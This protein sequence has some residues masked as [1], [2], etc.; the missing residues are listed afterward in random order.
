MQ[1]TEFSAKNI[2]GLPKNEL[3][4]PEVR[5][6]IG[7]VVEITGAN[8][9]GKTS[10]AEALRAALSGGSL[11]KLRSVDAKGDAEATVVFDDGRFRLERVGD[12]LVLRE[13]VKNDRKGD[14]YKKVDAP[15]SQLNLW[16][17]RD[18]SNPIRFLR[19]VQKERLDLFLKALPLT[20]TEDQVREALGAD[21]LSYE[22]VR[23][24]VAEGGHPL[25]LL[26]GLHGAIYAERR[27]INV[28]ERQKRDAVQELTQDVSEQDEA[29]TQEGVS[30]LES[31]RDDRA[32]RLA[33]A[34]ADADAA[35]LNAFNAAATTRKTYES[36]RRV[37]LAEEIE[38]LQRAAAEDIKAALDRE[39]EARK[40]A[41]TVF[42]AAVTALASDQAAVNAVTQRLAEARA[43]LEQAAKN[44]RTREL[45]LKYEAEADG[46][47]GKSERLTAGLDAIV[48]LKAQLLSA[49]PIPGLEV[50]DKD[51][52]VNG[53]PFDQLNESAQLELATDVIILRANR[54]P[55]KVAFIDGA[56]VFSSENRERIK[57]KLAAAD[58]QAVICR[59]TDGPLEV[60]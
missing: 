7:S 12:E 11:N 10:I 5:L 9:L 47:K 29:G 20:L 55:L 60:A 37:R 27:G 44:Q 46:L 41:D 45:A 6:S 50:T 38:K 18:G 25:V 33:K 48:S 59:V 36:D 21:V 19:A 40:E 4:V 24:V 39:I 49:L 16:F 58:V 28:A 32:A 17:D 13:R 26:P 43:R 3:G 34:R 31:E 54:Y 15:Q 35:H 51:I 23:K 8:G 42:S 56:E 53:V 57:A 52:F 14:A 1:I 2:L 22:S 30:A